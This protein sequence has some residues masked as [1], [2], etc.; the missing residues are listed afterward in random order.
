MTSGP[1]LRRAALAALALVSLLACKTTTDAGAAA[2]AANELP[3]AAEDTSGPAALGQVENAADPPTGDPTPWDV[4]TARYDNA[5]LG[6]RSNETTLTPDVLSSGAFGPKATFAVDGY[7]YAQPLYAEVLMGGVVREV[8]FVATQHD[9]VYAFDATGAS[10][11]PLWR[12]SLLGAGETPLTYDDVGSKDIVPEIGITGTPVIDRATG[13]LFVVSKSKAVDDDGNRIV[14]QRLHALSLVDGTEKLGGPVEIRATRGDLTFDPLLENQRCALAL[15]GGRVWVTWASHGDVGPYHGWLLGYDAHDLGAPPFAWTSTTSGTMG[16]IWMSGSGPSS[17]DDQSLFLAVGNGTF[18][19]GVQFGSSAVR[20]G[21][22]ATSVSVRDWFTPAEQEVMTDVDNDFG[23]T[24]VLPLGN[25]K[26]ITGDKSGR[27][28][29]LA[30]DALGGYAGDVD[31]SLQVFSIPEKL[32]LSNPAYF[33]GTL[34]TCGHKGRVAAFGTDAQT[35]LFETTPRSQSPA[36]TAATCYRYG[37]TPTVSA[38]GTSGAIVWTMDIGAFDTPGPSVLHAYDA[39]DLSKELFA[40][41]ST[42]NAVKFTSP[43]V[44]KGRVF[45]AGQYG[46]T[47]FGLR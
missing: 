21:F 31:R 41:T 6:V 30:R 36:C 20:L 28:Y 1:S 44:T 15:I 35:G 25:G 46:V 47:V 8:V 24:G 27:M 17:D 11:K 26:V 23:T 13:R 29:V 2:P 5:R 45:V 14:V 18:E 32:L 40:S 43:V 7:V 9:S 38:N 42:P 10:T 33:D 12:A 22:D 4:V 3:A 19:N 39:R 34:Y 16:G 37:C